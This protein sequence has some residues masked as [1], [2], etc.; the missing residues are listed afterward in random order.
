[1]TG[2]R[3]PLPKFPRRGALRLAA[4][5]ILVGAPGHG[6]AQE[7]AAEAAR[8][9]PLSSLRPSDLRS[10]RERPLFTPSR[11]PPPVAPSLPERT[12]VAAETVNE[13]PNV[14][15]TGIIQGPVAATAVL[16]RPDAGGK[17]TVRIGDAV[18]GWIV[19]AIDSIS[20][21]LA[22]GTRQREYRLFARSSLPV[23][24]PDHAAVPDPDGR[25]L[26]R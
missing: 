10:F 5:L 7:G 9:N 15:L 21:K 8:L 1:M 20:I 14:R 17:S 24:G 25:D 22:S 13:P 19:T 4:G 23:S 11:K 18:D 6:A 3:T 16:E 26:V 12:P 2:A